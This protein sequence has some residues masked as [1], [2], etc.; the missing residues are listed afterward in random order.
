MKAKQQIVQKKKEKL[1][2]V[3]KAIDERDQLRK[4]HAEVQKPE[5]DKIFKSKPLYKKNEEIY[6]QRVEKEEKA[7]LDKMNDFKKEQG[8]KKPIKF[9]EFEE[10]EEKILEIKEKKPW[11]KNDK[12]KKEEQE[13]NKQKEIDEFYAKLQE[14]FPKKKVKR[15]RTGDGED[16]EEMNG[17][18][19]INVEE[20]DYYEI[21]AQV[22]ML[23]A[24]QKKEEGR[25]YWEKMKLYGVHIQ[26]NFLPE[27]S[28]KKTIE[29][30]RD[31]RDK[32]SP[33]AR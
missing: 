10:F 11:K 25:Q 33:F 17:E 14:N 27:T 16:E 23:K 5:L 30:Y 18:E 22:Q 31:V 13:E 20:I 8:F 6:K 15:E 24:T 1:E 9:S 29:L 21:Q 2:A 12:I 4:H 3:E 32:K 28:K 26:E 19:D 7:K